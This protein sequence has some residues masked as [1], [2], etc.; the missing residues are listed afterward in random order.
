MWQKLDTKSKFIAQ[1]LSGTKGSRT[2]ED[3]DNPLPEA[4]EMKA[5]ASG[6]PRILEHA[7]LDRVVRQL[8][9]QRRAFDQVKSRAGWEEKS[10][11]SAIDLYEKELPGAQ[12]DS[13]RAQDLAGP[14][15][16]VT[17]GAD[18]VTDRQ[19]AGER[20]LDRLLALDPSQFIS[21]KT[22]KLGTMSGFDMNVHAQGKYW[23]GDG[24][25]YYLE[26]EPSLRNGAGKAYN[27][28]GSII[29]GKETD[30]GRFVRRFE[31]ILKNIRGAA[32][33]IEGQIATE[34]DNLAHRQDD[35]RAVAQGKGIPRRDRQVGR[36]HHRN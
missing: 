24:G 18:E 21:A 34:K 27:A 26:A 33:R 36:A 32:E 28:F 6:D 16:K 17:L 10:A 3:I 13:A 5:A 12:T 1:V 14:K 15:F 30:P 7:E 9:A 8:T 11:R 19:E 25:Q 23:P 22:A 4:A 31:N 29:V 35:G 20:R 2:A